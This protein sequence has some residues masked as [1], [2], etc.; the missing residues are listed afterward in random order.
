[1]EYF[2]TKEQ[3][4]ELKKLNFCEKVNHFYSS[5][6]DVNDIRFS[7]NYFNFNDGKNL[8]SAPTLA[9]VQDWFMNI[10]DIKIIPGYVKNNFYTC[11]M[12][13]IDSQGFEQFTNCEEKP[14][15]CNLESYD[16]AL[17]VGIDCAI[18]LLTEY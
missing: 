18:K 11:K 15:V 12:F 4:K 8:I 7:P 14:Y 2:V 3:A 9:Q 6:E 16:N 17:S 5:K 13:W 1:M 10:K